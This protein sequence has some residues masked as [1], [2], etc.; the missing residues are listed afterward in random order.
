MKNLLDPKWLL[1]ISTLPLTVLLFLSYQQYSIIHSLLNEDSL[2]MWLHFGLSLLALGLLSL[3][4]CIYLIL[5]RINVQTIYGFLALALHI[6]FLYLLGYHYESLMPF[7]IPRWMLSGEVLLYAGTFLMPTMAFSVFIL[8]V[9]FSPEQKDHK[10]WL[11]FGL[12]VL[13]P[14]FCFV[15]TQTVLPLWKHF[16]TDLGTHSIL[17]IAIVI[18]I[19]FFF[20]L[21]RGLYLLLSKKSINR[22]KYKLFWKIPI[23]LLL[24]LT[25]LA[26]NNGLLTNDNDFMIFG[27]FRSIWFYIIAVANGLFICLPEL[28]SRTTRLLV[29][30]AKSLTFSFTLYFFLVFLP[31]LPLSIFAIIAVGSGFLMLTPVF[32]FILHIDELS[33]DF[34]YLKESFRKYLLRLISFATFLVIPTIITGIYYHDR[35]VIHQALNYVYCPD[36]SKDVQI[37]E[38]SL[39]RVLE[40]VSQNKGGNRFMF[41]QPKTPYLSSLYNYIVLDNLTLSDK[42]INALERIF[43]GKEREEEQNGIPRESTVVISEYNVQ[44]TYSENEKCWKSLLELSIENTDTQDVNNEFATTFELPAGCWISDYYLKIG[45]KKEPGILSEKKSALW[46]YS[47]IRNYRKDPGILYYQTGNRI[48]LRVF[49]VNKN[50]IRQT[51]IEF[52]HREPLTMQIDTNN[53]LLGDSLHGLPSTFENEYAAWIPA[54]AKQ[55]LKKIHRNPYFNFIIDVSEGSGESVSF[56]DSEIEK[57]CS[58]YPQ[59]ADN[60]NVSFTNASTTTTT[61][62]ADWKTQHKNN[63]FKGGFYVEGA[64]RKGLFSAYSNNTDSY[65]VFVVVSENPEDA[66]IDEDFSDLSMNFP[67]NDRFWY[68]VKNGVL[69]AHSLLNN[70]ETAM[71]DSAAFPG[72]NPVY[73][74]RSKEGKTYYLPD[75]NKSTIVLKKKILSVPSGKFYEKSWESALILQAMWMSQCLHPE[76]SEEYWLEIVQNSFRTK[77]LTPLTSYIVVENEAQKVALKNKQ[78]EV[79]AGNKSLDTDENSQMMSEPGLMVMA[80]LFVAAM[81]VLRKRKHRKCSAQ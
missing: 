60:A 3:G 33:R 20:F 80:F 52:I 69:T 67:D 62:K 64:I 7:S 41:S 31:F 22:A 76:T 29:F 78:A 57:L 39:G 18:T 50:E 27:D 26:L 11:N 13:I 48:T 37:D 68:L 75:D 55:D 2:Q 8:V 71:T 19:L 34:R 35:N 63:N 17:V 30:I 43:L 21:I 24:P 74:F 32:L 4:Y 51:G 23:A 66:I 5:K 16:N 12:A 49:P 6:T 81:A 77:V 9:K 45:D 44:S 58:R 47:N 14:L 10:I 15:F 46:V 36:Y 28:K 53:I 25:G 42:K 61:I 79:L 38:N 54:Q 59:M 56:L 70:P 40:N 1:L 72:G 65:P 73:K